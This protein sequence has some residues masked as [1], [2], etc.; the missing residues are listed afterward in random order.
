MFKVLRAVPGKQL[1][2]F[3]GLL[4][5]TQRGTQDVK[6]VSVYRSNQTH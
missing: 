6:L 5:T 3:K 2:L 1:E 4:F